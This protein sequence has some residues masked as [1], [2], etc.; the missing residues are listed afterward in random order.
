MLVVVTNS[1]PDLNAI[2]GPKWK[3]VS[4]VEEFKSQFSG[5][6]WIARDRG[7][8]SKFV[9]SGSQITIYTNLHGANDSGWGSPIRCT[10]KVN[11]YGESLYRHGS[12]Q[13]RLYD[14]GGNDQGTL[15]FTTDGTPKMYLNAFECN[16]GSLYLEK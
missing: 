1:H 11:E 8:D 2:S 6:T 3:T 9:V 4:N 12:I 10:Y 5:T 14:Q 16:C 15:M 7:Y 13:V